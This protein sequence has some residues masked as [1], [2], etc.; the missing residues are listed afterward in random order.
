MIETKEKTESIASIGMHP[1]IV[2]EHKCNINCHP[3]VHPQLINFDDAYPEYDEKNKLH[4]KLDKNILRLNSNVYDSMIISGASKMSDEE[5]F[6]KFLEMK[7]PVVK[8]LIEKTYARGF[9]RPSP[10]QQL[11]IPSLI[12]RKDA[13]VQFKSGTGKTH[14][15]LFGL[16]W[17]FDPNDKYVQ[18]IF[19][20]AT[21]EIAKQI[22]DQA[23]ELLPKA[24]IA[25]CIGNKKPDQTSGTGGFKHTIKTSS[26]SSPSKTKSI[27]EEK[28]EIANAQIIVC[29]MGKF[30]YYFTRG[31]LPDMK[32]LK[33]ICVDE[34]DNIVSAT[35]RS[36][37]VASTKE[38]FSKI[39]ETLPS[40]TQRVF[41]SATISDSAINIAYGYFRE[42][43][44]KNGDPLIVL[45]DPED[46]TLEG[47]RQYYVVV[48][49]YT[50]KEDVLLDILQQ[51]RISQ[52]IVFANTVDTAM[53]I[54]RLLDSQKITMPSAVFHG[55]LSEV[56]RTNIFKEFFENK[57]RLLISTDVTARGVDVH[58]INLVIN[59]DLP[60]TPQTYIHRIGRSGRFG[61]KGVAISFVLV[62]E[63]QDYDEM[64]KVKV[65]ND[66]SKKCE[67]VELPTNLDALL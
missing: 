53:K 42:Y 41:F 7:A 4:L 67:M 45:L 17:N 56:E 18:Y 12:L 57:I 27:R 59:F 19:V 9:E 21:H 50:V 22:Y 65:I 29:T 28:A 10:V 3:D 38:Q 15:F 64:R 66:F 23:I 37:T 2:G 33:T 35:S 54:K 24:K 39:M 40:T 44:I 58:Q 32:Y 25:L 49:N 51:C 5:Y 63:K 8:Q 62:N 30:F 52:C 6:K 13:L 48:D 60:E 11:T 31:W 36:T 61:K 1:I 47:I 26:L 55:K 14:S 34:F 46:Y 20:T 43:S 16:L